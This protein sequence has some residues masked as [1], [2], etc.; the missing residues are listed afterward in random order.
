M[1]DILDNINNLYKMWKN[2]DLGGEFMPEDSNP[3]LD[4]SSV[5][6]YHYF[7]LPMALNYQRNSYK[8]WESANKTYNDSD[9]KDVFVPINVINMGREEVKRKLTK[10]GVALQRD[11]QT[12][13]WIKLCNTI[14]SE[15]NVDIR[16]LF[17]GLNWDIE[18]ILS[19]IQKERK[20]DFPYISG[21]KICN[22]WLYVLCNYT[23][24][25]F[26]NKSRLNIAP[27]THVIQASIKLGLVNE[28]ETD[29]QNK[30]IK[31]WNTLLKDS[32]LTPIDMH[33]PLWL[34]S[35]G[36]FINIEEGK[37]NKIKN[38]VGIAFIKNGKL[39]I[40]Q[41]VKSSK[42]NKFTFVGGGIEDGETILQAVV[43]ECKEEIRNSF[44]IAED[45]FEP[46]LSFI[47]KSTSDPNLLINM[48]ILLAKKQIDVE[49]EPN[50]EILE[51]RWFALGDS[52]DTLSLS[53]KD[54]FIQYAKEKGLMY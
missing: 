42:M 19:Y 49:L 23:N 32:K 7:T 4:K 11:K 48:N 36:G 13:I 12:D 18:K 33:T 21:N 22:Y 39:L 2:G 15:F 45:D 53:I 31:A 37:M 20:T 46:L 29:I 1:N 17:I 52:E 47:E 41:S 38:V 54:H 40:S 50:D 5:D 8:L 34:W 6:N 30:I 51:Y 27:D 28:K 44:E 43:R 25:R 3:H 35:R 24:G 9:T 26:T 16:N 10:Y 14:C